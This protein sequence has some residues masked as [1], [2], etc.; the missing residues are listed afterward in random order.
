LSEVFVDRLRNIFNN[1]SSFILIGATSHKFGE[2]KFLDSGETQFHDCGIVYLP[3]KPY[4]LC[5]MTR[6]TDLN[7]A[8][9]VIK[10]ISQAVYKN[11]TQK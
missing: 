2:R 8:T 10:N 5:I 3:K 9:K 4:L 11:L 6:G 1:F 7:K